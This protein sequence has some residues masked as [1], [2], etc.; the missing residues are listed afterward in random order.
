[1]WPTTFSGVFFMPVTL[2][3]PEAVN[4]RKV[5][6]E[7]LP[8]LLMNDPSFDLFPIEDVAEAKVVWEQ[9]TTIPDCF[10]PVE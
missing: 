5:E 8:Y 10:R 7:K 3:V 4:I 1:M 9:K 2:V 6:Q